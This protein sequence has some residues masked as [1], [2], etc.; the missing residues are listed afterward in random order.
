MSEIKVFEELIELVTYDKEIHLLPAK[1]F[2]QVKSDMQTKRFI[3]T[4]P[5]QM[6][7]VR[8]IKAIRPR[9]WDSITTFVLKEKDPKLKEEY[10]E[11]IDE[12][13]SKNFKTKSV[14][15]LIQIHQAKYWK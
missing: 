1:V 14:E 6:I 5:N 12:R 8:N 11:I 13:K 4:W 10:Q 9:Q 15:H 3:Q 2:E 7:A